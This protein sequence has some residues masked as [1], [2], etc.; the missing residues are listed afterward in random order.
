MFSRFR[1]KL[2]STRRLAYSTIAVS[3]ATTAAYIFLN[4]DSNNDK[5]LLD[6]PSQL[7]YRSRHLRLDQP[8]PI[9]SASDRPNPTWTPPTRDEMLNK[10]KSVQEF[11]L[12]I[13]G[14]GATG[15]GIALDAAARGLKVGLVERDDFSSG[16][17][18]LTRFNLHLSKLCGESMS[19]TWCPTER[20]EHAVVDYLETYVVNQTKLRRGSWSELNST[21]RFIDQFH[22][23]RADYFKIHEI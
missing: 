4:D 18:L 17:K 16:K 13:V 22:F 5:E 20:R 14:G 6:D 8:N 21:R 3:T 7:Y 12:L 9:G 1:S 19:M 23:A 2:P 10:L 11:D 15:S